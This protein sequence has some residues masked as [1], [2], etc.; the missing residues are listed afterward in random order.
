MGFSAIIIQF[1]T[2]DVYYADVN[3]DSDDYDFPDHSFTVRGKTRIGFRQLNVER[4]SASPLYQLTIENPD[5]MERLMKNK[6][7][8]NVSL[9]IKKSPDR[10][11][12]SENLQIK[13][14]EA[15]DGRSVRKD[16]VKLSLNTMLDSGLN[17][18]QYW[19]D[20][21]SVKR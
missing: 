16:D 10:N 3:L 1:R 15:S 4:W 9:G 20:S 19:L 5:L 8:L 7:V 17:D 21:G 14:V 2:S 11:S 12:Y 18:S 6:E 13:R